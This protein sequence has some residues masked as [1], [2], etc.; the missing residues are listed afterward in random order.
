MAYSRRTRS[1]EP[2]FSFSM[3]KGVKWLIIV[4]VAVFLLYFALVTTSFKSLFEPLGL[5]PSDVV[6]QFYFWQ[7]VTYLFVHSPFDFWHILFN[8]L[9][10]WMFGSQLESAWGTRQFLR[11]Y[12]LCGIGAGLCVIVANMVTGQ[13]DTAGRVIGASGAIFG[14]ILAFGVVFANSTV[15]FLLLFPMKA[16]YMAMIFGAIALLST[17]RSDGS[18]VSHVAHLG[19]MVIGLLYL[20]SGYFDS[21][22]RQLMREKYR[23]WKF[24]RAKRKFQVY[25][26]KQNSKHDHTVQ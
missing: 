3:T 2:F 6:R 13:L 4:N 25:L 9:T 12:F 15:L 17:I 23:D 26:K 20:K 8:M 10:L 14:L 24:R 16:K 22:W 18:N 1:F 21:N 19:G 11:Y 5:T 7:P